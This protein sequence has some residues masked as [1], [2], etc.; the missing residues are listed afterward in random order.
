M[1]LSWS[2]QAT[3]C[4]YGLTIIYTFILDLNLLGTVQSVD[5]F[6]YV[7]SKL[8]EARRGIVAFN[9][10]TTLGTKAVRFISEYPDLT[11]DLASQNQFD[12]CP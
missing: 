7:V 10:I 5:L 4:S 6:M 9:K 12:Y 3:L 11:F 2:T 1:D 8:L